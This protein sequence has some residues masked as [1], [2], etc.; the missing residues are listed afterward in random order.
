MPHH[1]LLH[2]PK[3]VR[4]KRRLALPLYA[5]VGLLDAVWSFAIS[6]APKGDIGRF[7][8][9]EIAV[10]AD[11]SG[12][13]HAMIEALHLA[14]FLDAHEE[15]R[16]IIHDW[17]DHCPTF[18]HQRLAR[19]K[20]FFADGSA[21]KLR[22]L[23][24]AQK[25]E[26]EAFYAKTQVASHIKQMVSYEATNG[27]PVVSQWLASGSLAPARAENKTK[28]NKTEQNK[29][30]LAREANGEPRP[31][32]DGAQAPPVCSRQGRRQGQAPNAQDSKK[33]G[34]EEDPA[35]ARLRQIME[36]LRNE[37]GQGDQP[38]PMTSVGQLASGA[39]AKKP[40]RKA[41]K[42]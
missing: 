3:L 18:I 33:I 38:Q 6:H 41:P 30:E 17:P 36:K 26:A 19:A 35:D 37:K 15:L 10:W 32:S 12:D 11:Y 13:E 1:E 25:E 16:Y 27:E 9:E 23:S 40:K 7:T 29:T 5:A 42:A 39:A 34:P 22:S 14:G 24:A 31:E 8:D 21:P 4:L 28:Q 20:T 2:H